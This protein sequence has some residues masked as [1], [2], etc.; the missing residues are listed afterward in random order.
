VT[1]KI[2]SQEVLISKLNEISVQKDGLLSRAS[3]TVYKQL[4]IESGVKVANIGELKN[5][6]KERTSLAKQKE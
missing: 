5:I 1:K 4:E 6:V 2:E 3:E